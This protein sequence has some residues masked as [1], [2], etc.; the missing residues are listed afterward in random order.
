[1]ALDA[2]MLPVQGDSHHKPPKR[3]YDFN[4]HWLLQLVILTSIL[5]WKLRI[6]R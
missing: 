4:K 5:T 3:F 2:V 1:M 6:S